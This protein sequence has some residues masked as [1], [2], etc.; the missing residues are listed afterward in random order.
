M[1]MNFNDWFYEFHNYS[2]RDDTS[3]VNLTDRYR[4]LQE[5]HSELLEKQPYGIIGNQYGFEKLFELM[6]NSNYGIKN[7]DDAMVKTY[8]R[9]LRRAMG[10]MLVNTHAV[11]FHAKSLKDKHI[12]VDQ[13]STH[14]VV[15]V[16]YDQMHF[17]ERDE[18]I[19]Q[20]LQKM[21][22][23][24]NK[25][26]IPMT[27]FHTNE[28]T[29]ILDFS[30]IC[31]I[32]GKICNE[33][34]IGFDDHGLRFRFGYGGLP[35]TDIIIYKLDQCD[36]I[37]KSDINIQ[38]YTI[39]S[40]TF[41]LPM[42]NANV[43]IGAK[44]IVDIWMDEF[45]RQVQSVPN[46]G[47][48][49]ENHELIV[50]H[51]QPAT[52]RMLQ[53]YGVSG[54]NVT[55][56]QTKFL[57]EVPDIFPS[58][59]Y[60]HFT[61]AKSIYTDLENPVVNID[62][63]PIV[64]TDQNLDRFYNLPT[65][66]PPICIDRSYDLQFDVLMKCVNIGT[67][68]LKNMP[69]LIQL[70]NI[71]ES[72][73][74]FETYGD[75]ES[76]VIRIMQSLYNQ[77]YP[78]YIAYQKGALLTSL[79]HEALLLEDFAELMNHITSI[80]S[81]TE[82]DDWQTAL[83]D[84][85]EFLMPDGFEDL[86]YRL[87]APYDQCDALDIFRGTQTMQIQQFLPKE[88]P[89]QFTHPI[90]EQCFIALQYS[91]DEEAWLFVCPEIKHFKGI[92]NTFYIDND[93]VG[94][95]IFKF[96]ILYTETFSTN[97]LDTNP[98]EEENVLDYDQFVKEVQQYM[99]FVRYWDVENQLMKL[100]K[101][102]YGTYNDDAVVH[103]LSDM[104][105]N[106]I[107]TKD[108]VNTDWSNIKYDDANVTSDYWTE[109]DDTSERAPFYLNYLFYMLTILNQC[110]ESMQAEFY[111]TLTDDQFH[112]RY[113]D[114]NIAKAFTHQPKTILNFG[115]IVEQSDV[116]STTNPK[117][118][119]NKHLYIG[120]TNLY[121]GDTAQDSNVYPYTF[122]ITN[123]NCPLVEDRQINETYYLK[124]TSA[125]VFNFYY[126]IQLAKYITK[127]LHCVRDFLGYFE[128]D[129]KHPI[130]QEFLIASVKE[131]LQK[132]TLEI[133]QFLNRYSARVT[134][135]EDITRILSDEPF[136]SFNDNLLK[137]LQ[138]AIY[139]TLPAANGYSRRYEIFESVNW[140]TRTLRYLYYR[141][142][143]KSHTVRRIRGLYLY[144]K[145]FYKVQ[146]HYQYKDLLLHMDE[147]Y[148]TS[149]KMTDADRPNVEKDVYPTIFSVA[150]QLQRNPETH[151]SRL[152]EELNHVEFR[153]MNVQN[154]VFM[155]R[156][157]RGL[158]HLE[159]GY[160][161]ILD[162]I[163]ETN[164]GYLLM[165]ENYVD[166]IM[167]KYVFDMYVID[168]IQLKQD[169]FVQ[170]D[171]KPTYVKWIH[172]KDAHITLPWNVNAIDGSKTFYFGIYPIYVD[173]KYQLRFND[174]VRKHCEYVFFDGTPITNATFQFYNEQG[175]LLSTM[176]NVTI[177][178]HRIGNSAD[179]MEDME[180][181]CD[182]LD[183]NVDLQNIHENIHM[184][185][186]HVTVDQINVANYEMLFANRYAQL[187]HTHD[188]ILPKETIPQG[189]IDRVRISNQTINQFLFSDIGS[190]PSTQLFFKPVQIMHPN[191]NQTQSQPIGGKYFEG[192]RIYLMTNDDLHYIFPAEITAI[193]KHSTS[194]GFIE[195]KVD[196]RYAK[197][198][199]IHTRSFISK[200]LKEE[201]ECIVLDDNI[202]NFLDEFS[203]PNT[204]YFYRPPYPED[205]EF[206][207][208]NFPNM[209]SV[210]GDPIFIQQHGDYVYTRFNR[211][212]NVLTDQW[213]WHSTATKI[214]PQYDDQH[215]QYRFHYMGSFR[216]I[217][218]N[219]AY[220]FI[221]KLCNV[222][223][224][225]LTDPTLYP[226]LR[227]E[228]NDHSVWDLEH[229]TYQNLI[230]T[231]QDRLDDLDGRLED[232]TIDLRNA[233]TSGEE[234]RLQKVIRQCTLDVAKY[235]EMKQ[236][237]QEYEDE[238]EH[239]TTWFN[240]ISYE[241][242]QTYMTNNRTKLPRTY[243]FDVRDIPY[244]EKLEVF[245]YDWDD[246]QWI[247][248][249]RYKV[250]K[251]PLHMNDPTDSYDRT[252][253]TTLGEVYIEDSGY[254]ELEPINPSHRILVY[255][256]YRTSD[257]Y[258]EIS[259]E[260]KKC[261]VRFKP[262]LSTNTY[263]I[264]PD[265]QQPKQM[266]DT[267]TIR[268]YIDFH[269]KITFTQTASQAI[270]QGGNENWNMLFG[271][272]D[273]GFTSDDM[274][275][276]PYL[277]IRRPYVYHKMDGETGG[278]DRTGI[279]SGN[280]PY[281]PVARFCHLVVHEG[282]H[283]WNCVSG[284]RV[285]VKNPYPNA[286]MQTTRYE[287][288]YG[289]NVLQP[290]DQYRPNELVKLICLKQDDVVYDPNFSPMMFQCMTTGNQQLVV[291][292]A[293]MDFHEVGTHTFVCYVAHDS[294]YET[295][296]G[297]IVITVTCQSIEQMVSDDG[298]WHMIPEQYV[299]YME[300]PDECIIQLKIPYSGSPNQY[301]VE[302]DASYQK[303]SDNL[304]LKDN[305]G[306]YNPFSFY[307]DTWNKLRFP[308]S[309]LY[310]GQYDQRLVLSN[311]SDH[312]QLVKTNG[313]G[314]CRYC[315]ATIP[316]N[317]FIDVTGYIPTPLSRHR[318][319]FWVNGRQLIGNEHLI[320]LSPT[321]FQ[322]IQLTS[323]KNFELIELV[324][325]VNDTMLSNKGTVY[326]DIN[327]NVY[328]NYQDAF[329]S[330]HE[331]IQQEIRYTF[332]SFPNH[333][334]LQN[335]TMGF[336][337]NPN[338]IDMEENIMDFWQS[339]STSYEECHN[340]P[341]INGVQLYHPNADDI[342]FREIP[343]T[344][345]IPYFDKAWKKEILTDP[346]FPMTHFD[347]SMTEEEQY[348]L[349]HVTK[350]K[351]GYLIYTTGNYPKYF[352]LYVSDMQ[353]A[354]IDH[355]DHTI[356]II[357]FV[358]CGTRIQLDETTKG[359]WLHATVMNYIS[360]KIQ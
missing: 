207:D 194:L 146:N 84:M 280:Y 238:Q 177:T 116:A 46:F 57:H 315:C 113:L 276:G 156:R 1:K 179:Q 345:I 53:Q 166:T 221:I 249:L 147:A 130:N 245:L 258:N 316:K 18:F 5:I 236:R 59:N 151:A 226:I 332:F 110:D 290:M 297:L 157:N 70:Q 152:E 204:P 211:E 124:A 307:Y 66:T 183:T 160:E 99:G 64:G 357:P 267:L 264:D 15:D 278:T 222:N 230:D 101:L 359:Y 109:Y 47:Y 73:R 106:K 173:G 50:D 257:V 27:E 228:P 277:L 132:T 229:I 100:T 279:H 131:S 321:S 186:N 251:A 161:S 282:N 58:T 349:L 237:I 153:N 181:L 314:I 149:V 330:N 338:N 82:E 90:S 253:Q 244:S 324:D 162:E 203:N 65:C 67:Q 56:F 318:Y 39:H 242:S 283:D 20:K 140:W 16:P 71:I 19:R 80:L 199:E 75:F 22:D 340:V 296:G 294:N 353:Y 334:P 208:D 13:L 78:Y 356:Q 96:F 88:S 263:T 158:Q 118:D 175:T 136:V 202:C 293:S 299:P 31:V 331:I 291:K 164:D 261:Y 360:K 209:I 306:I 77:I 217:A 193:D 327:G 92:E 122:H 275:T 3:W 163:H 38:A 135:H 309:N 32:N 11:I 295:E 190:K 12:H 25:Q 302:I 212:M 198:F 94:D 95:E 284:Y 4:H 69:L 150:P 355:I 145:K 98:F 224:S 350:N 301:T 185:Q 107:D 168:S 292:H 342:G 196:T 117:Q 322:L 81:M 45:T 311:P 9:S 129:Y 197:W 354:S 55:I 30:A 54:A 273:P 241:A 17:G 49:N 141:Y 89:Y 167:Q 103:L 14:Y 74:T 265:A 187:E 72:N 176:E 111:R 28:F 2:K 125:H 76:S 68:L 266:Y 172:T 341:S 42:G 333:T 195:A 347:G 115:T 216:K 79:I 234:Y 339:N 142:G 214:G 108:L 358:R 243:Q 178:F 260:E 63:N 337:S 247:N 87:Q 121:E 289:V 37:T 93:L 317:G 272:N 351:H 218:L 255:F 102:L 104:L 170:F 128:T 165:L 97:E 171:Q 36:V 7:I 320:I 254:T 29:K 86:A 23:S 240:V 303:N 270:A 120:M 336:V 274:Y 85:S 189:P 10:K 40:G 310:H 174:G 182:T 169:G 239:P 232:L 220:P 105:S 144:F 83:N 287:T 246:K 352:S 127:Y 326:I 328:D 201:I 126:D 114:Y 223:R 205:L 335:V 227:Q 285:Y 348:V 159:Q 188:L 308:I 288:S 6:S 26:F 319:E 43:T 33:F 344:Q 34:A 180:I 8:E 139:R 281:T 233:K 112:P 143:Y 51:L 325:D 48:I 134:F 262:I 256:A 271:I 300:I 248:P 35:E 119:H 215:K 210:P 312:I 250:T 323:L 137:L 44:C 24:V 219:Q 286:N 21:H 269:E 184:D 148:M 123:Q 60:L 200:Y 155:E 235:E 252:T 154:K 346:L 192:Q 231:V 343:N 61:H 305:S 91:Y 138:S 313:I 41:R 213:K 133:K 191:N 329:L 52:I 298:A 268:K 225:L 259:L 206:Y 304:I 62:G